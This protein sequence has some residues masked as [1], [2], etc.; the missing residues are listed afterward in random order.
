[1]GRHVR[2][3]DQSQKKRVCPRIWVLF[4]VPPKKIPAISDK[5][6]NGFPDFNSN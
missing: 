2:E 6:F 5:S 4:N 3:V 1:M